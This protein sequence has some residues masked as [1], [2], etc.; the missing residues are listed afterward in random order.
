MKE[1]KRERERRIY[2]KAIKREREKEIRRVEEKEV[3]EGYKERERKIYI[4]IERER[5][6]YLKEIKRERER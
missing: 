5:K 3:F 4:Y 6:I 1:R 2:L